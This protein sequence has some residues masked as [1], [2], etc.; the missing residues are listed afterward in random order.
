VLTHVKARLAR[1]HERSERAAN[2]GEEDFAWERIKE[3]RGKRMR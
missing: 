1:Y 3:P 2:A